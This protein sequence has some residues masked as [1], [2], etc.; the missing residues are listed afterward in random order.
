M[1]HASASAQ[2]YLEYARRG[3][4]LL[5]LGAA[6]PAAWG[7]SFGPMRA[8]SV[9]ASSSPRH[10]AIGDV[11]GDNRPDI[12]TA[13]YGANSVGVSLAGSSGGF[14]GGAT[15]Y[16]TGAGSGPADVMLGD[17]NG[18]G[19]PDIIVGCD[20]LVGVLLGQGGGRF[21]AIST[22]A[23]GS[24]NHA[25]ALA[26]GDVNRDG[27]PDIVMSG[28]N[29]NGVGVLLGQ[30]GG[31][32]ATVSTYPTGA[33]SQPFDVVVGDVNGDGWADIITANFG[34]NSVGVLL[35]Q[36]AG[37][38]AAVS[39][40]SN[41][42][43]IAPQSVSLGDVNSDG[44]PDIVT[45]SPGSGGVGVLLG[46][47]SGGFAVVSTYAAGTGSQPYDVALGDV[48][49]DNRQDI[50]TANFGTSTVGI[51]LGQAGGFA[52]ITS[53]STGAGS[54]PYGVALA[55][56]NG[57]NRPD[58]ISANPG[59]GTFSV[60]LNTGTFTP[61]ATY[62]IATADASLAP[63]PAHEA[64]TVTLRAAFASAPVRAELLNALGQ[65]VRR[66]AVGGAS[67]RVETGGLAPGVYTLRLTTDAGALARRVVLE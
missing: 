8:Y 44:R 16:A 9:G 1:K 49:G 55:D 56:V 18:D 23:T 28:F 63:N 52:P 62:H 59:N 6:G 37:G 46:L 34:T 14:A 25:D 31:R 3:A 57:D 45:A 35:G 54:Y 27:R 66:P 26:L 40:Y 39:T 38:F 50:I 67:F 29:F 15:F 41:G 42:A 24:G 22:Y 53:Y 60:L 12:I 64:F 36:I 47:V 17:V 5:A 7:Q 65:V 13:N 48:N 30:A 20:G 61:L 19:Q 51:F 2:Y 4:L 21:T 58:I 32:F 33:G 10:V 43:G 11:N